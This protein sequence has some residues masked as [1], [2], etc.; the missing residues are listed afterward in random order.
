MTEDAFLSVLRRLA[1]K[2]AIVSCD[3]ASREILFKD[4]EKRPN[5]K[6]SSSIDGVTWHKLVSS[7][8][9]V[10]TEK[11]GVWRLSRAGRTLT[12]RKLS[13]TG[14]T[15]KEPIQ[16]AASSFSAVRTTGPTTEP[17]VDPVESPLD[18]LRRRKG[19]SGE[20]LISQAQ[21]EAGE[22][23]RADFW[24]A[25]MTPRVTMNWAFD[26]GRNGS[27][28]SGVQIRSDNET[29]LMAQE[30]VRAA[31]RAVGPELSGILIDVCC[32]LKGIE[33][34]EKSANWPKRSGKVVLSMALNALARHYGLNSND[35]GNEYRQEVRHWGSSDYRPSLAMWEAE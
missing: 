4:R 26:A 19:K 22:R 33:A 13:Q 11:R 5:E 9:I 6:S 23:L 2:G 18:R 20:P 15:S 21:Y 1:Q 25:E 28:R 16:K 32:H 17:R 34:A 29:S 14:T 31:L 30:R 7:G 10:E 24:R 12:R 27:R 3:G 8:L 35:G